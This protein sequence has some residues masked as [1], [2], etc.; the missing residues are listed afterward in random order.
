MRKRDDKFVDAAIIILAASLV[1]F[2]HMLAGFLPLQELT[3]STFLAGFIIYALAWS[4]LIKFM[5][6]MLFW[7]H[8]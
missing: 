6:E 1:L 4:G 2:L 3:V 8:N 7:K 5:R